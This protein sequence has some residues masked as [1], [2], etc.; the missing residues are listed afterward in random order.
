MKLAMTKIALICFGRAYTDKEVK[1]WYS[2]RLDGSYK[3]TNKILEYFLVTDKRKPAGI[4]GFYK[5]KDGSNIF[6]LGYFGLI[7]DA[8]GKG[9]GSRILK[10]TIRL[11]KKKGAHIFG[12]WSD[13]EQAD[14]FYKENGFMRIKKQK[15]VIIGG[16]KIYTYPIN[17]RFYSK[18]I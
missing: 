14:R 17:A 1:K 18:E 4:T 5:L 8:R 12:A 3:E 10:E 9:L 2:K 6:W 16:K 7:P 11:A 15:Y 13:N